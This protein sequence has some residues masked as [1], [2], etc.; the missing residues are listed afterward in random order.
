GSTQQ[1]LAPV[2]YLAHTHAN[3]LQPTGALI[4]ADDVEIHATGSATNSGV[5]R[6]G[7]QTVVSATDILNRGG[8]IGSSGTNGTTVV[9]ATSDV[10]N[11]SGQIT[12]NRV[13][14]LAGR[15]IVNTTLVDTVGVSA[16]SGNSKVNATLL[17][18]Q[19]TIASTGDMSVSAGRDLLVH[20]ANLAAG[21]DAQ[22]TAGRDITVD[23]VQS[24][25]AQSVTKNS[26]H[27]W[28][29]NSTTN[30][31]SAISAGGSLAT[32][33]GGDTTLRGAQVS[34][35]KDLAVIAGGNLTATTV[36]NEARFDN[37]ATDDRTRKEVDHTY[38]QQAVA[39]TFAA[40]RN[41]TLAAVNAD[42][43][44]NARTDGKGNVTLTGSSVT[45]GTNAATPGSVT[46][47]GNGNVTINEGR[48][49]HDSYTAV[50]SKRGSIVHGSTT[51]TMQASQA[52]VGVA[53]TVS[54]DSVLVQSGKDLTVQG[55]NVVGTND[56]KL[57][58]VG[59][60]NI[61]TSQDTQN[62]QSDYQK[63]EYGFLSGLTVLNQLDGGLQGYT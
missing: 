23:A 1:V 55:S 59:N 51:D 63:R 38:D 53:S 33:S 6:G 29:A 43:G 2:V 12:G 47:A 18:A 24:T 11:A 45:S 60:V 44:G 41:A 15:D 34:S 62:T 13:A 52:N 4:A 57:G 54:G 39:T 8:T 27:H 40:G 30:E 14:V 49:E 37:V 10:I 46:I 25:T 48:E 32:Q 16:V 58:A 20:G 61:T 42:A 36:T 3:D 28:E 5:I 31:T 21:G 17:G 7:T 26:Q 19:G 56:V 35:G 22:I 9:S 50:Q